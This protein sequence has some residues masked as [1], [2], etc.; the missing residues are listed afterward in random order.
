[1]T[2]TDFT[3]TW[4]RMLRGVIPAYERLF[5]EDPLIINVG[6]IPQ[7]FFL[8]LTDR[9]EEVF[10]TVRDAVVG[11]F[12]RVLSLSEAE[13]IRIRFT[14]YPRS[15][16]VR[17]ACDPKYFGKFIKIE[18]IAFRVG[19]VKARS[20]HDVYRCKCHHRVTDPD[21]MVCPNCNARLTEKNLDTALSQPYPYQKIVI[22]ESPD[23]IGGAEQAKTIEVELTHELAG[24]VKPG[25]R[26][27]VSG[28]LQGDA[29]ITKRGTLHT[30][31][32]EGNSVEPMKEALE[33]LVITPEDEAEIKALVASPDFTKKI[34]ASIA[35]TI[36]GYDII[37]EAIIL[38]LIGGNLKIMPDG[39]RLRGE[40]HILLVGD[41]GV[42]KSQLLRYVVNLSPRGVYATGGSSTGVGLTAGVSKEE[43]GWVL[44]AG[45]LPLADGGICA[46]DEMDKLSE[47]DRK[48]CHDAMEAQCVTIQK[49]VHATLRARCAIIGAANPKTGRFDEYTELAAQINFIPS[50]LNRF[51]LIFTMMDVPNREKDAAISRH[52]LRTHRAG[53]QIAAGKEPDY[54]AIIP[55]VPP[56][57]LKKFIATAK[58]IIPILTDEAENRLWEYYNSIRD[59]G[60]PGKPIPITARSNDALVRLS[61]A[62]AKMRLSDTITI[63]DAERTIHIVDFCLR[64][65]TFDKN[66]GYFDADRT[67]SFSKEKRDLGNTILDLLANG[68]MT[69]TAI[70]DALKD[71]APGKVDATIRALKN[72]ALIMEPKDDIFRRL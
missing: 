33:D 61:E 8:D 3:K 37:K 69:R 60:G 29:K 57:L 67:A 32:L 39:S 18:G 36:Y 10:D 24:A 50:F 40:F 21:K 7:K 43:D 65:V 44:T 59:L 51:D 55:P 63:E 41:P 19:E 6:D 31:R 45:A 5:P 27:Y 26:I 72:E 9:P 34:V 66:M 64:Q 52:I 70:K 62:S 20:L 42:A 25:D 12:T 53:S 15:L 71:Y 22:Q 17:K 68:Q 56:A 58:R 2:E 13:H 23:D 47:D 46:I 35:P 54:A 28:I 38:Q 1:M 30:Y 48:E 11:S 14:G 49:I 4:A 16:N